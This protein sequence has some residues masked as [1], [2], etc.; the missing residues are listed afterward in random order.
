MSPTG[1]VLSLPWSMLIIA[2]KAMQLKSA[3]ITQCLGRSQSSAS[4][5]SLDYKQRNSSTGHTMTIYTD[6]RTHSLGL[7]FGPGNTGLRG[8]TLQ[9][10]V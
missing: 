10:M 6:W 1:G 3:H 9:M 4:I 7:Q 5:S 2:H 8:Q